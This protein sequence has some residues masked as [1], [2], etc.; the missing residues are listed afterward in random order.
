MRTVSLRMKVTT[1]SKSKILTSRLALTTKKTTQVSVSKAT[2][3]GRSLEICPM[4]ME[5]Q[6]ATLITM[7]STESKDR[8]KLSAKKTPKKSIITITTTM[9]TIDRSN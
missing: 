4:E 3:S 2:K 5:D 7:I 9:T 8:A 1:R 6:T